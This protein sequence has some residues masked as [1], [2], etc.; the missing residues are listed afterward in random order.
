MW[1]IARLSLTYLQIIN[2]TR[3]E[4]RTGYR[5]EHKENVSVGQSKR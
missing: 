1:K 3:D 5:T 2:K 4:P